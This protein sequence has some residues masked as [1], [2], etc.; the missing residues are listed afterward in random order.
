VG[1]LRGTWRASA[2]EELNATLSYARQGN[3]GYVQKQ[4]DAIVL[5]GGKM[6]SK[7]HYHGRAF[8]AACVTLRVMHIHAETPIGG[9]TRGLGTIILV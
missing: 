4:A 6:N 7:A 5:E 9:S 1:T 2:S 3:K 8:T